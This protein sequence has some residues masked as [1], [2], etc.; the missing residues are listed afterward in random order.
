M[1]FINADAT[2]LSAFPSLRYLELGEFYMIFPKNNIN[3]NTFNPS[4]SQN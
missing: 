1:F 3:Q 4:L 2:Y